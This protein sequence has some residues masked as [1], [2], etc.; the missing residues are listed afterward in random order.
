MRSFHQFIRLLDQCFFE[1]VDHDEAL[2]P[3]LG[4]ISPNLWTDGL[5]AD[6]AILNDWINANGEDPMDEET[7]LRA[8]IEFLRSY[9]KYFDFSR[10]IAWLQTR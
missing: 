3:F 8:S 1:P 7:L 2:G 5:P 4:M 6:M 10:T 9:E